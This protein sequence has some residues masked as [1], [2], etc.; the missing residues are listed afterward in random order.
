VT[1]LRPATPADAPALARAHVASWRA[2]YRG[3]L[4]DAVLPEVRYRIPLG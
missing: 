1:Q 2:A 3:I 4:P